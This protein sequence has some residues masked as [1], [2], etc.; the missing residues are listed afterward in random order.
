MSATNP[1]DGNLNSTVE[2]TNTLYWLDQYIS[3]I[4]MIPVTIVACIYVV[5]V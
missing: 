5:I 4:V 1:N 2:T 3:F